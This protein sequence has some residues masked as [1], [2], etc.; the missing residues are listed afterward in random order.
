MENMMPKNFR[1]VF[2]LILILSG[3]LLLLQRLGIIGG[4]GEDAVFTVI[5]GLSF[6]YF[7][8]L[9]QADRSR[10]WAA[11]VSFILL[12]GAL[13]NLF[14]VFL[15]GQA[16]Q[17]VGSL[18]LFLIGLGFLTVYLSN[19]MLWWAIIPSGVLFSLSV[20]TVL[21]ELPTQFGFEPAGIL[22][23]GL[24]LTFL[25]LYFLR[26]DGPRLLWAIY[27]AIT[28]FIFGLFIGFEEGQLWNY[29]WPSLIV[30]LG[31]YFLVG[32]LR[33]GLDA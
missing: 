24:G 3:S 12:G 27:P 26:V 9:F 25:I 22:F 20:L 10:W 6:L 1:T 13:G 17:Y 16:G 23:V 31:I 11:L 4:Q 7:A 30:I 18:V 28:L 2:G 19:R 5:Y 21:E 15:P 14:E 33:R 32:S 8:S 29:I